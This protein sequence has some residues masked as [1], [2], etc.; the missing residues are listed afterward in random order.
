MESCDSATEIADRR[1]AIYESVSRL[2]TGDL[3]VLAGKGHEGG[4]I[5]G[6]KERP[7][8]DKKVAKNAVID[9][10]SCELES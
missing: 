9:L 8:D 6:S 4:Q 2:E 1:Q 3:L 7:F 5:I 10:Y